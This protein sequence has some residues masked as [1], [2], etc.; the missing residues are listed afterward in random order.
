MYKLTDKR[1]KRAEPVLERY[2]KQL[3][4]KQRFHATALERELR[5]LWDIGYQELKSIMIDLLRKEK[6]ML[7]AAYYM[8]NTNAP[9]VVSEFKNTL[10]ELYGIR[11]F[12]SSECA[13]AQRQFWQRAFSATPAGAAID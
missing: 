1:F 13:D 2:R 3:L 6:F 4:E 12:D 10:A 8:E 7:V 5:D 11:L 9:G